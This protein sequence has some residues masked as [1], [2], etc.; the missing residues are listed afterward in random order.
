MAKKKDDFPVDVE[1]FLVDVSEF[2]ACEIGPYTVLL[3]TQWK[4]RDLPMEI[5]RLASIVRMPVE[6]FTPIWEVIKHK[7]Y[8]EDGRY[9]NKVVQEIREKKNRK[10]NA[11]SSTAKSIHLFIRGLRRNSLRSGPTG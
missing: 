1:R 3:F 11:A 4:N 8:V 7:F 10:S 9:K 2:K 5:E 6:D